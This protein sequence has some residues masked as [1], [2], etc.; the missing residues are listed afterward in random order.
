[1]KVLTS[2]LHGIKRASSEG[3]MLGLFW[4]V[5][6]LFAGVFYFQLSDYLESVLAPSGAAEKFLTSFDMETFVE[7]LI[8][9]GEPLSYL[10]SLAL[11]LMLGYLVVNILLNGGMLFTLHKSKV[12]GER[13]RLAPLF[14]EGAGRFFGRFFRLH[15]YSLILWISLF[16]FILILNVI[17][18]PITKG[19]TNEK[20]IFILILIRLIFGLF[21]LFL[22]KMIC[23]Y[24]RI[25]IVVEDSR[26]VFR[27]LFQ[28]AGFVFR[29]LFGTLAL[30]YLFVLTAAAVFALYWVVK[31]AIKTGA[32]LPILA[33]FLFTQLF[34]FSRGW[35]RVGLQAAQMEYFVKTNG[36][37]TPPAEVLQEPEET[38]GPQPEEDPAEEAEA[39]SGTGS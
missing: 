22:I 33:A 30:Y 2:Y 29:K 36:A 15:I 1:M 28:S 21:I 20:L 10:L 26:H 18:A 19:G 5:N 35:I 11:L 24:A 4:L 14:F 7:M 13:R 8:H 31:G 6:L 34:I 16:I 17:L 25:K 39:I 27:A 32:L 37:A 3:K 12:K 38:T 23:D 9:A